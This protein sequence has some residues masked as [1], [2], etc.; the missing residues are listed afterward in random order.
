MF[1]SRAQK[2]AAEEYNYYEYY[3]AILSSRK[4]GS[5]PR[6]GGIFRCWCH[7]SGIE[8]VSVRWGSCLVCVT[9]AGDFRS[10]GMGHGKR[11]GVN[12]VGIS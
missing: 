3:V 8:S 11:G 10:E 12:F 1:N 2:G 7:G 6:G 9:E 5:A 4:A